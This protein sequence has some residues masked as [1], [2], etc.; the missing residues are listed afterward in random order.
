M[1]KIPDK[2]SYKWRFVLLAISSF[3]FLALMA[4]VAIAKID[5]G[6]SNMVGYILLSV[7]VSVM[8]S[9]GGYLGAKI[10]FIVAASFNAAAAVYMLYIVLAKTSDGWSDLVGLTTYILFSALGMILGLAAQII[11]SLIKRKQKRPESQ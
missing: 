6:L 2:Y 10:Y 7:L 1:L 9:A 5:I 8:I 4:V 3:I 11:W